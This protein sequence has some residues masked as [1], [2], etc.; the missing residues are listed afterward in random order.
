ME[1]LRPAYVALPGMLEYLS[2]P[3]V[4]HGDNAGSSAGL[5]A[6]QLG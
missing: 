5:F 6:R 1:D 3:G 2:R 4:G